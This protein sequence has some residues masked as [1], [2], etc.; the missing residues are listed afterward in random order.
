MII[1]PYKAEHL[2]SLQ[3]QEAQAYLGAHMN[4]EY[5]KALESTQSWTGLTGDRVIGCFGVCEMWTHRALMWSYLDRAAGRHLVS[6]H[7]AVLAYLEI[8]PYRRLEAEVDCEFEAGH[9]WLRMLGFTMECERMRCYRV[10]GGDSALYAR[11]K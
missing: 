10:D 2:A 3:A 1:V 4:D 11:V 9:R 7:R 8:A 6:I 5:A